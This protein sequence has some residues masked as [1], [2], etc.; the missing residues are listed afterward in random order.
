MDDPNCSVDLSLASNAFAHLISQ[1]GYADN[2]FE[3]NT[4]KRLEDVFDQVALEP[5]DPGTAPSDGLK[6]AV[7]VR[8]LGSHEGGEKTVKVV[9]EQC[10]RTIAPA[11]SLAAKLSKQ[12]GRVIKDY[13]FSRVMDDTVSQTEVFNFCVEPMVNSFLAGSSCLLFA[14]GMTGAGKTY[15]IVGDS[16][17]PGIVP[18][19]L[20]RAFKVRGQKDATFTM[21]CLEIYQETIYDLL[22]EEDRKTALKLVHVNGVAVA[23]NLSAHAISNAE[24]GT[25]L[26]SRALRRRTVASHALNKESSRSHCLC[27]ITVHRKNGKVGVFNL[28][29]LAG[30]ERGER[31]GSVSATRQR[32]AN[33]INTSLMILW[34]CLQHV[35]KQSVKVACVFLRLSALHIFCLC[36]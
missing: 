5:L 23:K 31:T 6:V 26:L 30:S 3:G 25:D 2:G 29:D 17:N 36:R 20:R 8:P 12:P 22:A 7:R 1:Q 4:T 18:Q 32:E 24:E 11:T 14:Y 35:R 10:L 33:A 19:L 13:V 27:T 16:A 28:V 15:T 21:S 34:R 9:A